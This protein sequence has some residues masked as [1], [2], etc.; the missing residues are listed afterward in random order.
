MQD[1]EAQKIIS[2][3]ENYHFTPNFSL[4]EFIE[5]DTATLDRLDNFPT[6]VDVILSLDSL[7]ANVL[8]PLRNLVQVPVLINSGYRCVAL[9]RAV[10]G[11]RSSQHLFGQAADIHTESMSNV[12]LASLIRDK[13]NFDQLI[14]EHYDTGYPSSGWVHVSWSLSTAPRKSI[15]TISSSGSTKEGLLA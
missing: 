1:F 11:A 2:D 8:Q 15:L 5:S 4:S 7:I 3:R 13:L 10:R 6:S 9:N 14:L 12:A